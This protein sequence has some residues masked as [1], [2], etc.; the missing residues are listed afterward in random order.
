MVALLVALGAWLVMTVLPVGIGSRIFE[1]SVNTMEPTV[2]KG[3]YVYVNLRAYRSGTLPTHGDL[4]ILNTG[5][6]PAI[7]TRDGKSTI[8]LE[9]AVGLP[10]DTIAIVGGKLTVNGSVPPAL[11]GLSYVTYAVPGGGLTHEG[12]TFT[13]PP[14]SVYVLGDNTKNSYDSRFWGPAPLKALRGRVESC[15][16][17]PPRM[18]RH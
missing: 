10:G 14:D 6:V 16:W 2:T 8:F 17:P 11:E 9:R 18:R 5:D 4:V 13:V 15:V 3:D 12:A 1:A 7:E